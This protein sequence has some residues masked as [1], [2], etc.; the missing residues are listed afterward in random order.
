MTAMLVLAQ[1]L[2]TGEDFERHDLRQF[3]CAQ[4]N[5]IRERPY[6]EHAAL[7][8]AAQEQA[9]WLATHGYSNAAIG[10]A[11]DG[12]TGHEWGNGT[13]QSRAAKHGFRGT[14]LASNPG[15]RNQIIGETLACRKFYDPQNVIASWD[16]RVRSVGH[17]K[18][19]VSPEFDVCG[20]G[21]AVN[22]LGEHIWVGMYGK[23]ARDDHSLTRRAVSH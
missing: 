16:D 22:P 4:L 15:Y 8:A 3:L 12:V 18:P 13:S 2:V 17:W 1:L 11:T 5:Q 23:E 7:N 9:D 6:R 14:I 21:Y 20:F 10:R 19:L